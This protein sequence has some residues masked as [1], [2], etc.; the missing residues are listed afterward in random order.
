MFKVAADWRRFQARP[1]SDLV[2]AAARRFVG[3][4]FAYPWETEGRFWSATAFSNGL[5]RVKCGQ[6]EVFTVT[7]SPHGRG[8]VRI[9]CDRSLD[10]RPKDRLYAT[11]SYLHVMT[12]ARFARFARWA[13]MR[14]FTEHLMRHTTA[15]NARSHAPQVFR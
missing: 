14:Q 12:L 7:S 4:A 13:E 3:N 10:W 8:E 5:L 11:R 2:I 9:L 1:E 15:M 6:Q